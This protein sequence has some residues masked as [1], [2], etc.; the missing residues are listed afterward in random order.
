MALGS[1]GGDLDQ[2]HGS[3]VLSPCALDSLRLPPR[4]RLAVSLRARADSHLS[5]W[6]GSMLHGALGHALRRVDDVDRFEASPSY[7]A[8]MEADGGHGVKAAGVGTASAL[9]LRP[10]TV[11]G[12]GRNVGQDEILDFEVMA[13]RRDPKNVAALIEALTHVG[14]QGLGPDHVH[15]D[16]S[17]ITSGDV[18]LWRDGRLVDLP[19]VDRHDPAVGLPALPAALTVALV[20]PTSLRREGEILREPELLDV[21]LAAARRLLAIAA[22]WGEVDEVPHLGQVAQRACAPWELVEADWKPFDARR[23]SSRQQRRH[24]VSGVLGHA[25]YKVRMGARGED[26][27]LAATLLQRA[28]LVGIGKGTAL[29]LGA[30]SVF[31]GT[32]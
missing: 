1:S 30:I 29:G 5:A 17:R 20:T 2:V 22:T 3:T 8:W 28:A 10:P 15:F 12:P 9:V 32:D 7:R 16:T 11:S 14:S 18:A 13:F 4:I 24:P 21:V 23:W 19:A 6:T 31:A 25:R 26:V 27:A